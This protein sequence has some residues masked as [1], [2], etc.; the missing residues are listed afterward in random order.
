E[1]FSPR[2]LLEG[3][4]GNFGIR[5]FSS[6]EE[7][8]NFMDE[9]DRHAFGYR[10]KG[11]NAYWGLVL[12]DPEVA[13]QASPDHSRAWAEL[14]VSIL[15]RLLLED[16]LGIDE[17]DL[18]EKRHLDYVR[19]REEALEELREGVEYQAAFIM[20]PTS[21]EEVTEIADKGEKMPQK[22]TD[23]YPK[24]LTGMVVHKLAIE[25]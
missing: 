23:F 20:N 21:L 5:R 9:R 14:D 15:H 3:A 12:E 13:H 11:G 6:S 8:F 16:C 24:L 1:G 18:E 17:S 25:K 10:P 4:R 22:S 7:L 2:G 19:G